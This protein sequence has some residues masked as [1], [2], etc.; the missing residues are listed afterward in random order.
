MALTQTQ[1]VSVKGKAFECGHQHGTQA[2]E[3]IRT[4]IGTYFCRWEAMWGV[5]KAE[6]TEKCRRLVPVIGNY[7]ADI[8]EELQG[9]AKGADLPLE[10][11]VALNARYELVWGERV[12][13]LFGKGGCTS[14]AALPEAT[15]NGRTYIGMNWDNAPFLR[16][17]CIVLKVAQ[18]GKPKVMVVTEAGLIGLKGMNSAGLGVCVNGLVSNLDKFDVK[19]PFFIMLRKALNEDSFA[20]SLQVAMQTKVAVSGNLLFAHR[21]G[22]AIDLEVTPE[23]IGIVQAENGILTHSNHFLALTNRPDLKNIFR[24]LIPN[25]L[26]RYRRARRLLEQDRGKIN[27]KSFQRVFRDHFS[28]PDSICWHAHP[29]DDELD[30]IETLNSVVMDLSEGTLYIAEGNPCLTDYVKLSL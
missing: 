30:Q 27:E 7:D 28:H 26:F 6:I 12:V 24:K 14:V 19:V 15:G 9:I 21:D 3:R 4:L 8:L 17:L 11:I 13:R 25:T 22:E 10:E 1:V 20:R 23:D 18:T 5:K 2:R 16:E 29:D